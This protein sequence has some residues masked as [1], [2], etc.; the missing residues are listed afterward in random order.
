MGLNVGTVATAIFRTTPR[1][2]TMSVPPI[3]LAFG[4]VF[5][6]LSMIVF[7]VKELASWKHLRPWLVGAPPEKYLAALIRITPQ[8]VLIGFLIGFAVTLGL[9]ILVKL[10]AGPIAA[11][12]YSPAESGSERTPLPFHLEPGESVMAETAARRRSAQ[13]WKPG[14]LI[15][16]DRRLWFFPTAWELE[17]WGLS[18][19]GLASVRNLRRWTLTGPVIRGVP[20]SLR[21]RGRAGE[22]AVFAVA[23]PRAVRRWF[24]RPSLDHC[25]VA[26]PASRKFT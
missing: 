2:A 20:D 15:L 5:W 16:T 17:P 8:S 1:N 9:A 23:E 21:I 6:R 18:L 12:W 14:T 10:L 26:G 4:P 7:A 22:E 25:L 11:R 19:D 24:N 3:R 13:G